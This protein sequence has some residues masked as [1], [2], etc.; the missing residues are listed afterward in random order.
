MAVSDVVRIGIVAGEASGDQ[1]GAALIE[2]LR[3]AAPG[4]ECFGV[5]GPKMRA[6]GCEVWAPSDTLSIMGLAEVLKHLPSLLR[7]RRGLVER[8]R[9][10]RPDVFVGI[11]APEFNL[12]LEARLKRSGIRTVQYVSPQVW[13][14]RQGRV[15]TIA[16]ACDRVLCLLPFEKQFYARNQVAADFIGHPLADR[17]PLQ[18]DRQGAREAL[19][20]PQDAKLI[21]LLPGSRI[22]EVERLG[23]DFCRAAVLI[24]NA[25]PGTRFITPMASPDARA[26]FEPILA[27]MPLEIQVVDGDSHRVL[28]ACDAAIVASGTATLE[29]MLHKR[30]MVVAYRMNG[31]TAFVLQHLKVVKVQHFA[32][33]NLLIGRRAVPELFQ[34]AVTPR[35]LCAATLHW[36]DHPEEVARLETEFLRVHESLRQGGA[37]RAAQIILELAGAKAVP[38]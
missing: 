7:F 33:P 6:A 32:Q 31:L 8:F 35:A 23:A 3:A 37:A 25:R 14:W 10:R 30:P 19:G 11:D 16:E 1:L 20:V 9:A 24:R 17:I 12:G 15:K 28:A 38:A 36:L 5:A 21:A 4:V 2:A 13:A 34:G 27:T 22:G 26:A 18:P 29:T